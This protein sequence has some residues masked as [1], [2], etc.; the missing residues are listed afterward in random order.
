[1]A[2][3]FAMVSQRKSIHLVIALPVDR[4]KRD[5]FQVLHIS[6]NGNLHWMRESEPGEMPRF[7]LPGLSESAKA[8]V[9]RHQQS[10]EPC[11]SFKE[12]VV[13]ESSSIV[14]LRGQHVYATSAQLTRDR[15]RYVNIHIQRCGHLQ[16]P[17]GPKPADQRWR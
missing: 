8:N 9:L 13:I 17:L 11:R 3:Q 10:S 14:F 12:L 5:Y 16:P 2:R 4:N 6:S 1:M 15:P 7:R